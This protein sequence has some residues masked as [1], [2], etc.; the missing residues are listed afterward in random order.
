MNKD[1]KDLFKAI[2]IYCILI[3]RLGYNLKDRNNMLD[4]REDALSMIKDYDNE[5]GLTKSMK[6]FLVHRV[7]RTVMATSNI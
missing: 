7:T 2:K 5:Y 4:V 3:N 1:L 6:K